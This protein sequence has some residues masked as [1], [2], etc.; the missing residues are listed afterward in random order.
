MSIVKQHYIVDLSSNNNL[1][2]I[3][4]MQGDSDELRYVEIELYE[5]GSAYI[6]DPNEI[7][8]S[9]LGT[10]PDTKEIWN[11]CEITSEGYILIELTRQMLA[12][13]GR[14]EYTVLLKKK[15]DDW[16]LKSFPFVIVTIAAPYDPVYIESSD[17]FQRLIEAITQAETS[18]SEA[19]EAAEQAKSAKTA[20]EAA[21]VEA[22]NA[23]NQAVTA[24]TEAQAAKEAAEEALE[25]AHSFMEH[26]PYIGDSGNWM[27]YDSN[28]ET[29]VD[30]G[31]DASISFSVQDVTMIETTATPYVTNSGT[32]THGVYHLFLPT[33]K[34]IRNVSKT[35][36]SGL[37][38]T[39]TI[40]FSDN[41]TFVYTV[42]NGK[43]AYQSAVEAGY[44]GT[45]SDFNDA[46]ANFQQWY[47]E[48]ETNATNAVTAAANSSTW[49]TA[50]STS[51]TDASNSA[52]E[53]RSYAKGGTN[54]RPGED[55][56][57]AKYYM[58]QARAMAQL[59]F[60]TTS[61][62]GIGKPDGMTAVATNGTFTVNGVAIYSTINSEGTEYGDDWL[63]YG[64][65]VIT[66]SAIQMY[67]V[68]IDSKPSLWTWDGAQYVM[69]SA[70]GNGGGFVSITSTDFAA[71]TT[72]ERDDPNMWWWISDSEGI[73]SGLTT[74]T[75]TENEAGGLT[76]SI[77]TLS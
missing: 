72:E 43:S 36:S 8:A 73:V 54:T 38:D 51:A 34:G 45:E 37:T 64:S 35:G 56:D 50:A 65:T 3:S 39:Y 58:E 29:Y 60:M 24:N 13:P 4:G 7:E 57:N 5:N 74:Y 67:L 6:P 47:S 55:T 63:K 11:T 76:V 49:A 71:L 22:V 19:I 9:I 14:G 12:V 53:S 28:T 26:L 15:T 33:A 41:T 25:D 44:T 20:A 2:Q 40:T 59:D 27:I 32:S 62:L 61:T 16:Q 31:V 10:K 30:S 1:V 66:P 52:I 68:Y 18:G 23:K 42:T 21:K 48:T 77:N 17:E 69:V 46:L 70:S 75:E